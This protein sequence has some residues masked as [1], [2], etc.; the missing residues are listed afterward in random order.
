VIGL[1]FELKEVLE[2]VVSTHPSDVVSVETTVITPLQLVEVS[3]VM[4][5]VPPYYVVSEI[6]VAIPPCL[7]LYVDEASVY[8]ELPPLGVGTST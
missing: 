1:P 7:V 2:V 3:S 4:V 6:T 8:D 5:S